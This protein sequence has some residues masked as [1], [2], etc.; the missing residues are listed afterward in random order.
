[1]DLDTALDIKRLT[2]PVPLDNQTRSMTLAQLADTLLQPQ[3]ENLYPSDQQA[4]LQQLRAWSAEV[5]AGAAQYL[6][7]PNNLPG[8]QLN[9]HMTLDQYIQK[10]N[11][12]PNGVVVP[13]DSIYL[14]MRL[15]Q[16]GGLHEPT[17]RM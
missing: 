9:D 10:D 5:H 8:L 11:Q 15:N 12:L 6:A 1:M 4:A 16:V 2:S 14:K 7:Q 3:W 17:F 13:G